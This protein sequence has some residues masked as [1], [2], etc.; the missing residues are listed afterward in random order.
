MRSPDVVTLFTRHFFLSLS[1]LCV[2]RE[3]VLKQKWC[4]ANLSN[5]ARFAHLKLGDYEGKLASQWLKLT[6]LH[7]WIAKSKKGLTVEKSII[8]IIIMIIVVVVIIIMFI[9]IFISSSTSVS[10]S[11]TKKLKAPKKPPSSSLALTYAW[12]SVVWGINRWSSHGWR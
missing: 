8:R 11:L 5:P 1:I 3:H 7:W 4:S 2:L 10:L 12:Q 6:N 9:I